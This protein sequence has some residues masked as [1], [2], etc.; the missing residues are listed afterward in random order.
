MRRTRFTLIE[1]L[2]VIA[3]IAILAAMLLPALNAAREKARGTQCLGNL[4]QLGTANAFYLE[5]YEGYY[6][7][8]RAGN[9]AKWTEFYFNSEYVKNDKVFYCP[10]LNR[11]IMPVTGNT[12]I[13]YGINLHN[14]STSYTVNPRPTKW[15]YVPE[16]STTVRRPAQTILFG[17]TRNLSAGDDHGYYQMNS[18]NGSSGGNAFARHSSAINLSW[19]DGHVS[20]IKCRDPYNPYNELGSCSS[21]AA[22]GNYNYWDRSE[23]KK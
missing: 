15:D 9:T 22:V 12:A 18:F 4:K 19:C 1:L 6:T 14:I 16:K 21:Y 11:Q 3:I 23:K 7:S 20:P 10:S 13:G 2:V 5:D 8:M 17:D